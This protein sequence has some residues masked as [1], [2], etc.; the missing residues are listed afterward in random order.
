MTIYRTQKKIGLLLSCSILFILFEVK[1]VSTKIFL[2]LI[3]N[4]KG[5]L[6]VV[7]CWFVGC[8]LMW[9][10][11]QQKNI[12]NL[13]KNPFYLGVIVRYKK[14]IHGE[15]HNL[16]SRLVHFLSNF[17]SEQVLFLCKFACKKDKF[18]IQRIMEQ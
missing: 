9:K 11:L 3:S 1:Y 14:K 5:G 17:V 10:K 8:L 13:I 7:S 12:M 6:N 4:I 2:F 18:F 16:W 15:R